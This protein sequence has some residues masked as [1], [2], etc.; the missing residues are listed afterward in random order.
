MIVSVTMMV[1]L[2]SDAYVNALRTFIPQK[3]WEGEK[4]KRINEM[5]SQMYFERWGLLA[6]PSEESEILKDMSLCFP[7]YRT[8]PRV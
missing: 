3:V 1:F 8:I 4:L 6:P 7:H 5:L 2:F